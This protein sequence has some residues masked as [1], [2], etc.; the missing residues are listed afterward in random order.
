[1]PDFRQKNYSGGNRNFRGD[2]GNF[3]DRDRGN[4]NYNDRDGNK[5]VSYTHLDVYKR[6]G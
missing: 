6:Q 2:R 4:R 3:R 1:M 5:A